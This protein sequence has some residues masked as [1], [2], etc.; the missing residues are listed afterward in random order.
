[1]KFKFNISNKKGLRKLE[2]DFTNIAL[3]SELLLSLLCESLKAAGINTEKETELYK[4]MFVN[5]INASYYANAVISKDFI[6]HI[7]EF[8]KIVYKKDIGGE[9]FNEVLSLYEK[10]GSF[11]LNKYESLK[12]ELERVG[13]KIDTKR[14]Y[15]ETMN[16]EAF[17]IRGF[18]I[19]NKKEK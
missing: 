9:L 15:V 12:R 3:E 4:E 2:Y 10:E 6:K 18:Q 5:L 1:M 11:D 19:R 14:L 13:I 17:L 7:F 16:E 8:S